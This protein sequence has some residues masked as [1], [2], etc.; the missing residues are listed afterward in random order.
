MKTQASRRPTY[1]DDLVMQ[2][3]EKKLRMPKKRSH[4]FGPFGITEMLSFFETSSLVQSMSLKKLSLNRGDGLK[5]NT[6]AF[7]LP[8]MNGILN[9]SYAFCSTLH[10][11]VHT[12]FLATVSPTLLTWNL[13]LSMPISSHTVYEHSRITDWDNCQGKNYSSQELQELEKNLKDLQNDLKELNELHD[14]QKEERYDIWRER[15]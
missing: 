14:Y 11:Y 8:I 7:N 10:A 2:L 9:L 6:N 15:A 1:I 13:P 5:L 4:Q 3:T 12:R